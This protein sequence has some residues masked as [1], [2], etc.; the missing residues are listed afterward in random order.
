M[1][2][3][4]FRSDVLEIG[5]FFEGTKYCGC[6]TLLHPEIL[7]TSFNRTDEGWRDIAA[8]L[9]SAVDPRLVE[10]TTSAMDVAPAPDVVMDQRYIGTGRRSGE[11]GA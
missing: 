4:P 9:C 6:R 5:F 11:A 10:R 3:D 8:V 2:T 1:A 7:K